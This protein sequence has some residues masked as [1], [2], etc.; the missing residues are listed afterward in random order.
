M[1]KTLRRKFIVITMCSI[2]F[3]LGGIIG[4]I[5]LAN[6]IN[7]N[8]SAD[9]RLKVLVENQGS[10]PH[11]EEEFAGKKPLPRDMSPEAPF[12]TRYFT[13]VIDSE[14]TVISVDTGRIAAVSGEMAESYAAELYKK[15]KTNGFQGPYKYQAADFRGNTMYIF[16]DC[17]RELSAFYS[18][19]AASIL[20]SLAGILLVFALVLFFSKRAVKPVA[21]SYEKQKRF[22]TDASHEIKTPLTIIDASTEVLEMENGENEWTASIKS[23]VRRLTALTEKLV[24][25]SRMDEENTKLQMTDFSLSDAIDET[26]QSFEAV[27]AAQGKTLRTT[28]ESGVSYY[29]DESSI[30]Q[31]V[32][33]LLDNA[34]KYS[35]ARGRISLDF[36]T[37]GKTRE[38]V[39]WNT[40][41]EIASGNLDILFERFYRSD[42]SRNS[43]T[44]GNGIGLSVAK[45]IV[46]AHKGKIHAKSEDGKS[47]E[48]TVIL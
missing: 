41:A 44:G 26:V 32:S 25:L 40:V 9:A 10:F 22:I 4:M 14:N 18:Y 24:F 6:Y 17:G 3:V 48:F 47:V 12:E 21:E 43:E 27:A 34:M 29:G 8:K 5:N 31:V 16:L 38:I 35:D 39:V 46:T 13:V 11:Q 23:Q 15:G 37:V 28:V 2:L 19:L 33:L 30:R 7:V 42:V 45:A 36:R 1:I 20:V